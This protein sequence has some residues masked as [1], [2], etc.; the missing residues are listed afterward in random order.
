MFSSAVPHSG[1]S[2][3][4]SSPLIPRAI[5]TPATDR[6]SEATMPMT[7]SPMPQ[8]TAGRSAASSSVTPG[9]YESDGDAG[10]ERTDHRDPA[11]GAVP[12]LRD[13]LAIGVRRTQVVPVGVGLG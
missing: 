10:E 4:V 3:V 1:M 13:A 6:A 5:P 7:A 12:A 11:V 8:R 9:G 2:S